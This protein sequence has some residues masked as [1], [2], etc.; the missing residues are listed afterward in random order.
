MTTTEA[1]F[2]WLVMEALNQLNSDLDS[3]APRPSSRQFWDSLRNGT[4]TEPR[5]LQQEFE[6]SMRDLLSD[7]AADLV[8]VARR[9]LF[10]S[11]QEAGAAEDTWAILTAPLPRPPEGAIFQKISAPHYGTELLLMA[12]HSLLTDRWYIRLRCDAIFVPVEGIEERRKA[13][14]Q[15]LADREREET[16][17]TL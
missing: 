1:A 10:T 16:E 7:A 8:T 12:A 5:R 6:V 4:A 11:L 3:L 13:D 9:R 14:L 17:W 2:R 15:A